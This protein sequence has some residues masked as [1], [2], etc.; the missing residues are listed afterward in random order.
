MAASAEIAAKGGPLKIDFVHP[1]FGGAI[2]M[3]HCPGRNSVD[4]RG[5]QWSRNLAE[6]I[7]SIADHGI[8][9]VVSLLDDAE[10]TRH[11]AQA[12][13]AGLAARGIA[14]LQIPIEDYQ[15]PGADTEARWNAA[16]PDLLRRLAAGEA[17][18]IHCAAGLGRTGTMAATLLVAAGETAVAA[19]SHVRQIRPGTVETA[20]QEAFVQAFA[21]KRLAIRNLKDKA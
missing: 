17:M 1:A 3:T 9:L 16:L 20:G 10:L 14:W 7:A 4:A 2:G 13:P 18:L 5:V 15:P 8:R 19:I 21:A 11:G 6:D 12:L